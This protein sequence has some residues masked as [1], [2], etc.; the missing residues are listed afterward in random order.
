[1]LSKIKI[2][3]IFLTLYQYIN[4][5]DNGEGKEGDDYPVSVLKGRDMP[6]FMFRLCYENYGE[7]N[8]FIH[9]KYFFSFSLPFSPLCSSHITVLTLL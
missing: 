8:P 2:K 3:F 1:M 4:R 9:K 7:S 5:D 6:S